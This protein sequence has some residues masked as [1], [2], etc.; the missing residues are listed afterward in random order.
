MCAKM[1]QYVLHNVEVGKVDMAAERRTGTQ[2]LHRAADLLA[3]LARDA[4]APRRI[5]SIARALALPEPTVARLLGGLAEVGLVE[6]LPH[7]PLW[8]L[9]PE[10][11]ALAQARPVLSPSFWREADAVLDEVAD[12]TGGTVTLWLRSGD[13]RVCV[14]RADGVLAPDSVSVVRLD[15]ASPDTSFIVDDGHDACPGDR[16]PLG[17]GAGGLVE[18]AGLGAEDQGAIVGRLWSR[19][20]AAEHMP[21]S[22]YDTQVDA[23]R[24]QGYATDDSHDWQHSFCTAVAL[25]DAAGA[26]I[27]DL[28]VV[29]RLELASVSRRLAAVQALQRAARRLAQS[30]S[31]RPYSAS[32]R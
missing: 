12:T 6:R 15:A 13:D 14:R 1:T 31:D 19:I 7:S 32:L 18:L 21:R 10:I 3:E 29:Q 17:I 20:H 22:E 27:G 4:G 11:D 25:T 9:G 24:E 28:V 5:A 16:A 2:T 8:R 26:L 30:V 23:L